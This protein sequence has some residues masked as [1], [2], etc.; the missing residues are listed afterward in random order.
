MIVYTAYIVKPVNSY[1]KLLRLELILIRKMKSLVEQHN[2]ET[3]LSF[4]FF[5]SNSIVSG[6]TAALGELSRR[7]GGEE[8]TCQ[9]R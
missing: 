6:Y 9:C 2:D 3:N 4:L 7:P 8:S 1:S 5:L